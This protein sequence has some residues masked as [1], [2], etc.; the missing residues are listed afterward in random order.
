MRAVG[1]YWVVEPGADPY[2]LTWSG[3]DWRDPWG[4]LVLAEVE[5]VAVAIAPTPTILDLGEESAELPELLPLA[6]A[7]ASGLLAMAGATFWCRPESRAVANSPVPWD[8]H[9]VHPWVV[10]LHVRVLNRDDP[11]EIQGVAFT[12]PC[13]LDPRETTPEGDAAIEAVVQRAMS[14]EG[15]ESVLIDGSR[16][17]DPHLRGEDW[18]W[19]RGARFAIGGVFPWDFVRDS[20]AAANSAEPTGLERLDALFELELG[21]MLSEI[22]KASAELAE[23]VAEREQTRP[24]VAQTPRRRSVIAACRRRVDGLRGKS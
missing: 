12:W 21:E 20:T 2:V 8:P 16:P 24:D 7:S 1:K 4:D 22:G 11:F 23:A 5:A 15:H 3:E 14:H 18:T 19:C 17:L 6:R 9:A 10:E 13:S